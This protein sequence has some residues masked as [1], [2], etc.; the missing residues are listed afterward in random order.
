M[1]KR[2]NPVF[3]Y[4]GQQEEGKERQGTSKEGKIFTFSKERSGEVKGLSENVIS[5]SLSL[6]IHFSRFLSSLFLCL[7]PEIAPMGVE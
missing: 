4:K 2:K 3:S 5:I 6:T 7:F 1:A